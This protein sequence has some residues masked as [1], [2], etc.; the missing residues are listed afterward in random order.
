MIDSYYRV[1]LKIKLLI[2][3]SLINFLAE[4]FAIVLAN[5]SAT[6]NNLQQHEEAL[7]DI[8]RCLAA[9]YPR[10][11]HYKVLERRARCLLVLKRNEEAI[12]A[13]Q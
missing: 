11:L 6:L 3:N 10:H 2:S 7:S 13:F 9:G 1:L 12:T 4:E 5:R 8:R